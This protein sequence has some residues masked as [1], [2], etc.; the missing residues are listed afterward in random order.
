MIND[1]IC[2]I[3]S[4]HGTGAIGIVRISG[5]KSLDILSK[6]FES[7]AIYQDRVMRHG[8]IIANKKRIDEVMAVGFSDDKTYTGEQAVEIYPHGGKVAMMGVL[9]AVLDAGAKLAEPGQFTKR[10]FING[11]MDLSE[12][13]AVMDFIGS[14]SKTAAKNSFSQ[15]EGILSKKIMVMQ[16]KLT[17]ILASIEAGIEYPEED[18]EDGIKK[19]ATPVIVSLV[20]EGQKLMETFE[21]GKYIKEGFNVAIIGKPNVGK[22][23]LLNALLGKEKAIVTDVAGT[24]RD[25][26]EEAFEIKGLPVRYYDTAGIHE[27]EDL[28][29]S[30]GVD[31]SKKTI[32]HADLVLFVCDTSK[33]LDEKD[34]LIHEIVKD[35]S[36][37]VVGNKA[38]KKEIDIHYPI[39]DKVYTCAIEADGV[40]EL[41]EAIYNI[42]IKDKE[43]IEGVMITNERHR[44][45]LSNF[46]KSLNASLKAFNIGMDLDCV[47]IDIKDAWRY[48]GEITGVTV[49]QEIID[50]IFEKFCLGK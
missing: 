16:N 18:L 28:V 27:S 40:S 17:D 45:V 14:I 19:S 13:E 35:K 32:E 10:A 46:I 26:I 20:D 43:K 49:S 11:K 31:R 29:E 7:T 24:T 39:E 1:T 47:A 4:P 15:L 30:I 38:D 12:A 22:S 50:R 41:E 23:S 37:L 34:D 25:V 5:D 2:A 48:L 21:S 33:E 8:F 36:V 3:A 44:Q 9:A 6:V 42:A